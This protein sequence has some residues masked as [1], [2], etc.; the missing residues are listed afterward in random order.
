MGGF[1]LHIYSTGEGG[2]AVI[3]DAG[4][5]CISLD[6]ALVQPEIAKF[7]QVCSYDR[8]GFGWSEESPNDRTSKNFVEEL[9]SLLQRAQ[10]PPPYILVGHSLGGLNMRLYATLYPDE[11][12]GMVLVDASH[13]DLFERSPTAPPWSWLQRVFTNRKICLLMIHTGLFR[14]LFGSKLHQL[15]HTFSPEIR[16]A[17][18]AKKQT[19]TYFRTSF[20]EL[21][22]L[23]ENSQQLK[24]AGGLLGDKALTVI[25]AK[26]RVGNREQQGFS[27]DLKA[28][29]ANLSK[30][31]QELQK[32]LVQKSTKGKQIFVDCSHMIPHENPAII[33][34]AVREM[35]EQL[36]S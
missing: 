31:H 4:A 13:E 9:H 25:T 10:I 18:H 6:W 2:P 23:K 35:F 21:A 17:R 7:T 14:L 26:S 34:D 28:Y 3:L 1:R 19:A 36:R 30:I 16:N 5:G 8:A 33:V 32:D 22:N 29:F 24:D 15:P 11:V 27:P 12:A 20:K